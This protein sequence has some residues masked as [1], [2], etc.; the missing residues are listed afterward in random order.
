MLEKHCMGTAKKKKVK[1]FPVFFKRQCVQ[2][3]KDMCSNFLEYCPK[4]RVLWFAFLLS[5]LEIYNDERAHLKPNTEFCTLNYL[6][7]PFQDP[8]RFPIWLACTVHLK[9]G[10]LHM[11]LYTCKNHNRN[12]TFLLYSTG[13]KISPPLYLGNELLFLTVSVLRR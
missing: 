8:G 11:D 1:G 5:R 10:F 7:V 13:R 9:P 4:D 6:A 12:Q 3:E 2:Q